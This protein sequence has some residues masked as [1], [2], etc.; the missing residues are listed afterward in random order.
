M[1]GTQ[2][3]CFL[4]HLIKILS[5]E[6]TSRTATESDNEGTNADLPAASRAQD[7]PDAQLPLRGSGSG[8][9][10]MAATV[11]GSAQSQH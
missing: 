7:A 8:A 5:K 10:P 9:P 6:R 11:T 4:L 2:Q 1:E 3:Q